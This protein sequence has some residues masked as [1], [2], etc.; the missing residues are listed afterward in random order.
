MDRS[1]KCSTNRQE[2]KTRRRRH[3]RHPWHRLEASLRRRRQPKNGAGRKIKETKLK[4]RKRPKRKTVF[5]YM[6]KRI[7][8][9][10]WNPIENPSR[11]VEA[12]VV[13][14][15]RLIDSKKKPFIWS[16]DQTKWAPIV[17]FCFEFGRVGQLPFANWQH[18]DKRLFFL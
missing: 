13:N 5:F 17:P 8:G 15:L 4:K 18:G 3:P 6:K 14:E 1:V 12:S 11:I 16:D 2:I 7:T 10:L 9:I